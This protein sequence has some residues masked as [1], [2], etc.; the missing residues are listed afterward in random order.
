MFL[1]G[2]DWGWCRL[3][4]TVLEGLKLADVAVLAP[5]GFPSPSLPVTQAPH[6]NR[7]FLCRYQQV[8]G[9]AGGACAGPYLHCGA[10]ALA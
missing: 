7:P 5:L 9:P 4:V 3:D 10:K 6:N 1:Y 2:E 8:R